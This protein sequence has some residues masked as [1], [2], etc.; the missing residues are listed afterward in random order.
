[1]KDERAERGEGGWVLG[2]SWGGR[3]RGRGGDE[4]VGAA[5]KAL[6]SLSLPHAL[7]PP[8]TRH[9]SS[10]SLLSPPFSSMQGP[11]APE[12]LK[13]QYGLAEADILK[14]YHVMYMYRCK[15]NGLRGIACFIV[16]L[17]YEYGYP[18][19]KVP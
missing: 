3:R 13:L 4:A 7:F 6:L 5:L 14:L 19:P 16:V 10:H 18:K 1:M 8:R 11:L 17:V 2:Q 15:G 9:A 12:T